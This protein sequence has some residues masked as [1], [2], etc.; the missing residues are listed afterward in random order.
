VFAHAVLKTRGLLRYGQFRLLCCS[1]FFGFLAS[2]R[3]RRSE[4]AAGD[5][6]GRDGAILRYS[7]TVP[8]HNMLPLLHGV[9]QTTTLTL[10]LAT[11]MSSSNSNTFYECQVPLHG[12]FG[13]QAQGLDLAT[14]DLQNDDLVA[15]LKSDIKQ[16]RLL[17][18]RGAFSKPLSGARQVELSSKLGTVE[19][20]FYQ[21]PR[22][23]HKDV[24]R[25]SNDEYEGCQNVGRSGWHIDGT[26]M[27]APFSYQTMYFPSVSKGGDTH[28][29][30]LKELYERQTIE[31]QQ[32]WDSY[33]MI[34]SGRG[35]RGNTPV[36]PLVYKHPYRGDTTLCFH[37]GE[38]FVQGWLAL[39]NDNDTNDDQ[40]QT[41]P[42]EES[43]RA[44]V[45]RDPNAMVPAS[46]IQNEITRAIENGADDLVLKMQWQEGDFAIIDNLGLAHYAS[47][48]TQIS[49]KEA[50][51][52]ILHRTTILGNVNA[53]H[54]DDKEKALPV[55]VRKQDG[56]SSFFY[57]TT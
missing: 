28:F 23:P 48:E 50:G 8:V 44:V 49:R 45:G 33:W 29:C 35:G 10:A 18:F 1:D 22:S 42:T 51:L 53:G 24:F 56:R 43:V 41:Q 37:C 55:A 34:T 38:P 6:G 21:H 11:T 40:T 19:S 12:L 15:Q 25:V 52:R 2:G 47:P 7:N 3:G 5:G 9:K 27:T 13:A 36:H 20:T 30:P 46:E 57:V 26:F 4:G 39:D 14:A 16:H 32:R 54:H 31:T 17:L